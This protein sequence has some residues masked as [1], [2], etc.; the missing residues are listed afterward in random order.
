MTMPVG[1][2]IIPFNREGIC[3]RAVPARLRG[4]SR[5]LACTLCEIDPPEISRQWID[6]QPE[7]RN[8]FDA[9][10]ALGAL[11]A[12]GN[13][14]SIL[15]EFCDEQH[16]IVPEYIE[17]GHYHGFCP[18]TGFHRFSPKLVQRV[19]VND[20]WIIAGLVDALSLRLRKI[21]MGDSSVFHLGRARFGPYSCET[22]FG[23]QLNDRSR[24]ESAIVS[25]K[26]KI[27]SGIG[28]LLTSTRTELLPDIV[29]ERCATI[30]AEDVMSISAG[31]IVIDQKVIL[32]ALRE[33]AKLP[34]AGG[35][36]FRFSPGFRSCVYRGK[37]FRFTDKQSLAVEALYNAWNDGL[38]GLYQDE[39]KGHA[40]TNQRMV[41]L[42]SGNSA[43]G[44]LIMND[45]SG[46][47]WLNL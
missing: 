22:F 13:A 7:L 29:P 21:A 11:V 4:F 32:A 44:K 42:F 19:A 45:G 16:W 34:K 28:V 5:S 8:S 27:G 37:Q 47:Y 6:Q 31:K 18:N 9:F 36:G 26:E 20:A 10:I 3:A 25:L 38:P 41:Q 40:Q 1:P 24:F 46:F 12:V 2:K 17:P 15:C 35:I 33:P 39:L 14:N 23:R 43:Y 30:M